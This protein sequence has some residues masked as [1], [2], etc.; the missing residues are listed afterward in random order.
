MILRLV[1]ALSAAGLILFLS[2]VFDNKIEEQVPLSAP[3]LLK[4]SGN[5]ESQVLAIHPKGDGAEDSDSSDQ[6][7]S[8]G[9]CT[10]PGF[11]TV[12][13][14][15]TNS[16]HFIIEWIEFMRI[17]G[18]DRFII[19]DHDSTDN[20][21]LLTPFYHQRD[22]TL[23]IHV[24]P[25]ATDA[26]DHHSQMISF[27]H[28][29]ETYGGSTEWLLNS[30]TDEFIFSPSFDTLRAMLAAIPAMELERN[31]SVHHVHIP[32][33]RFGAGGRARRFQHRLERRDDGA[34]AYRNGCGEQLLNNQVPFPRAP[35]PAPAASS[36]PRSGFDQP[37][38]SAGARP[39]DGTPH[40]Y[41][42]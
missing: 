38:T 9:A 41:P 7:C 1:G 32:C 28:C 8:N 11:L 21:S 31:V 6:K 22:P 12:C 40:E 15:A 25:R 19:Y 13:T 20:L 36:P 24:L 34:I 17:Q 26:D 3:K 23:D 39:R 18:V 10:A 2:G 14:T 5:S 35:S 29:L 4:V 16:V 27:Q 37:C 30:D 42:G 33:S